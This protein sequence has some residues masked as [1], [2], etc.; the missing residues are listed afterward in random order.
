MQTWT[1]AIIQCVLLGFELKNV[2]VVLSDTA[3]TAPL[4]L[5]DTSCA[6]YTGDGTTLQLI[7]C[8]P[9]PVEGRYVYIISMATV[10][11]SLTLSEVE[12]YI[13]K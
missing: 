12:V 3:T 8:T 13:G 4:Q 11:V 5:S 7:T 2:R 9:N 1:V 6:E 10:P